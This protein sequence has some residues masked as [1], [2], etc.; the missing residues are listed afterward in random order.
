MP[1]GHGGDCTVLHVLRNVNRR[2]LRS[3]KDPGSTFRSAKPNE[4]TWLHRNRC[5]RSEWDHQGKAAGGAYLR[6]SGP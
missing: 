3:K 6:V 1:E 5:A 2:E 4:T